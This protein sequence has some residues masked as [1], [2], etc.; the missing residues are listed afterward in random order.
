MHDYE[1]TSLGQLARVASYADSNGTGVL[2]D[3]S[4]QYANAAPAGTFTEQRVH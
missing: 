4:Y 1:Y 3:V 2:N